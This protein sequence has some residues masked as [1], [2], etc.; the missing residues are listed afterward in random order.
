ML[1]LQRYLFRQLLVPTLAATAAL[2]SVAVLSQSLQL[3][4]IVISQRQEAW[5]FIKLVLLTVP[6]LVVVVLPI[7]AFVATLFTVNK[8]HTEQE[9][10][11]CFAAGMSRWQVASPAMRLS[12]WAG[13]I[14]LIISL[15]VAPWCGRIAREELFKARTD[16]VGSLIKEGQ[17]TESPGGLTAYAQR[18]DAEGRLHNLFIHQLHPDRSS[19]TYDAKTG[20]IV[21]RNDVPYLVMRDGSNEQ[22]SPSGALNYLKFDEYT[23]DLSPYADTTDTL[24]YKPSDMYMHELMFPDRKAEIGKPQ[25]RKMIA[26]WNSRLTA[27]LYIPLFVLFA[28]QAVVGGAFSRLGYSRRI[29]GAALAALLIRLAGVTVQAACDATPALNVVQW[30]IPLVALWFVARTFL[31]TQRPASQVAPRGG[32]GLQPLGAAA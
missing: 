22:F 31:R 6:Y 32:G 3:L 13:L 9:I 25:R 16:L 28:L 21:R 4:T 5:L 24:G 10:V 27:P 30:A 20:V 17:F 1:S 23:L 14:M 19:A 7:T 11:V 15:W 8:L 2:G 29:G 18:V 26:E 12:A